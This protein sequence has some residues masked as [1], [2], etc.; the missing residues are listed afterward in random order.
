MRVPEEV[1]ERVEAYVLYWIESIN[2]FA[3]FTGRRWHRHD[4]GRFISLTP[5]AL[6]K[7]RLLCSDA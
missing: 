5:W 4:N 3:Y 1:M 7:S 6:R 2:G